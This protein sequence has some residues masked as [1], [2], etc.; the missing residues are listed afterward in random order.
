MF[1]NYKQYNKIRCIVF[2]KKIRSVKL[3]MVK[4]SLFKRIIAGILVSAMLLCLCACGK[5]KIKNPELN[6]DFKERVNTFSFS[7]LPSETLAFSEES[8]QKVSDFLGDMKT[9]YP[10]ADMYDL[11]EV[12]ERLSFDASVEKHNSNAL[13]ADKPLTP[14]VLFQSVIANNNAYKDE[15]Q[16]DN[17]MP[18]DE[19]LLELCTFIVKIIDIMRQ[20]YPDI[21]WQRV[22]CNLGNLKIVY[23][24]GMMSFA[25]VSE[26]MVLS[27]SETNANILLRLEGENT[28]S[29]V[30]THEIMHIIQ[31]GC[32]CENIENCSRRAGISISWKYSDKNLADWTWM[33]EGS[34]E[35]HMCN[36]TGSGAVSYQYKIDYLCS[37]TM[38]ILLRDSVKADTMEN[39]SFYDDPELLFD[40]FGCETEEE[41]DEL[42]NM[43][44]TLQVLQMQPTGFMAYYEEKTGVDLLSDD[45]ALNQFCYSLKPAACITLAKEFYENLIV[46]L[47]QNELTYNDLFFLINLFEGHLNQHLRFEDETKKEINEPFFTAYSS[48]RNTL[49]DALEQDNPELDIDALYTEYSI[50]VEDKEVL[51]AELSMLPE[52]KRDFLAE[53]A[54]WQ[55]ELK[56]LGKKAPQNYTAQKEG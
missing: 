11:E 31:I 29:D 51:N 52:E 44:I 37:M 6:S 54:Q 40:A 39:L 30:L 9:E 47:Q 49:F 36:V 34:A 18:D 48:I 33:V 2:T 43:M 27:I 21:D 1:L 16:F 41:R 15:A 42:L 4:K 25:Q 14:D 23:D 35:R 38:S 5:E 3:N 56:A 46:F 8:A 32:L 24:T 13:D 28:F 20:K 26:K 12:K 53:R 19:Y 22:Y 7:A 17:V 55:Y 10:Y 45:E 50:T